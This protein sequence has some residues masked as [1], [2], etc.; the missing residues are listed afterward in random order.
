M[1]ILL[2]ILVFIASTLI[3]S[4]IA[5]LFLEKGSNLG[6]FWYI[7]SGIF[8]IIASINS[9]KT[10]CRDGW[11]SFSIG[12]QGACSWHGGV[13]TRLTDFGEIILTISILII[14]IAIVYNW[15]KSK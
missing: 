12:R 15:N 4:V 5:N 10:E 13:T 11:N 7:F 8:S 14:A 2:L 6:C 3:I 9:T 1:A